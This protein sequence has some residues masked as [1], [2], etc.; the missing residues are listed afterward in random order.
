MACGSVLSFI[1]ATCEG[2]APLI[3]FLEK[4]MKNANQR[5]GKLENRLLWKV[6]I[7]HLGKMEIK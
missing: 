2:M 7:L 6:P 3:F 5:S 1:F 4:K